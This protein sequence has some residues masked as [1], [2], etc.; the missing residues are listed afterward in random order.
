LGHLL[1]CLAGFCAAL[2]ALKPDELSHFSKLRD[3]EV[4]HCCDGQEAKARITQYLTLINEGFEALT[5]IDLSRKIPTVFVNQGE[6]GLALLLAN[7]EHLINH[8]HQLFFYLKLI[9]LEVSTPDL[10][11]L[12]DQ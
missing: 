6:S 1:E 3:L 12:R 7:L 9:G 4:N 11:H 8:K 5:D 10:Y 2:Q